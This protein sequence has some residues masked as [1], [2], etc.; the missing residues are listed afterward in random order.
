[1]DSGDSQ[2]GADPNGGSGP[3][4]C[5]AANEG[6]EYIKFLLEAGADP[7]IQNDDGL[8]PIEVAAL[9]GNHRGV[10]ILFPVT[11]PIPACLDWSFSGLMKYVHSA[12]FLTQIKGRRLESYL[13]A[14]S[15]GEDARKSGE[16]FLA[17]L[18]YGKVNILCY[19][20]IA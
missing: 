18:H 10:S 7:N 6:I 8:R 17:T 19:N 2:A 20:D 14:K 11:S 16:Y 13:K 3:L 12:Q 15:Q 4:A 1:M 9:N 5:A